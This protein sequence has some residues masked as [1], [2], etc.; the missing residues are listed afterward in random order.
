MNLKTAFET[1]FRI[2]A[3]ISRFNLSTSADRKLLLDRINEDNLKAS[4]GDA[5]I[6]I[7]MSDYDPDKDSNISEVFE[8]ADAAMYENKRNLKGEENV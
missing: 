6:A 8:R 2:G 5:V 3:A 7:G 4:E 1:R